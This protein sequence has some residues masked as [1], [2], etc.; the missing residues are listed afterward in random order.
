MSVFR[1]PT[2]AARTR[3][4]F[5]GMR[6]AEDAALAV[7]LGVDAI[8]FVCVRASKRYIEPS[9]AGVIRAQLPPFVTSVALLSNPTEDEVEAVLELLRPDYLQFH[10]LEEPEF[11]DSFRHRY[12]KAI[13]MQVPEEATEAAARYPGASALLLDSHGSDGIGGTGTV[14]DWARVPAEL[15]HWIL[16]GGLTAENVAPAVTMARPYAVDVSSGIE[17]APGVKD[18]AKMRAFVAAVRRA[19]QQPKK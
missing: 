1:L 13:S 16:A 8:G 15:E 18:P 10:G 7:A 11:C 17:T 12:I 9:R 2:P 3:I 4:K 5:C 6:R 14:F 19:D